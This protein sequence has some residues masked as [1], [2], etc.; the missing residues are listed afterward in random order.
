M[1]ESKPG[2][3]SSSDSSSAAVTVRDW[4]YNR[5]VVLNLD[6]FEDNNLQIEYATEIY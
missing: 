1:F 5:L 6:D 3:R 4:V 2:F